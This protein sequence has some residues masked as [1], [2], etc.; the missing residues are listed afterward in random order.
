MFKW[1]NSSD[2][3]PS[4]HR[5]QNRT[6]KGSC[7]LG[8]L[9]SSDTSKQLIAS[10][11]ALVVKRNAFWGCLLNKYA[12]LPFKLLALHWTGKRWSFKSPPIGTEP[13]YV[14]SRRCRC[15][16]P[17]WRTFVL[18]D[19]S[20]RSNV[21]ASRTA[22]EVQ[23]PSSKAKILPRRSVA[24]MDALPWFFKFLP[25]PIYSKT[26]EQRLIIRD[27]VLG[28]QITLQYPEIIG[29]VFINPRWRL[30]DGTT[31][32][33]PFGLASIFILFGF[34]RQKV[35]TAFRF[36]NANPELEREACWSGYSYSFLFD[37]SCQKTP[38]FY[39]Q[40][41][42]Q[43]VQ[44]PF[45]SSSF[46]TDAGVDNYLYGNRLVSNS[47]TFPRQHIQSNLQSMQCSLSR[48]GNFHDIQ[49]NMVLEVV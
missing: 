23:T 27:R 13:S 34:S 20:H 21:C 6:V 2:V 25:S 41:H 47:T 17:P 36:Q 24:T 1:L 26:Q 4:W 29:N 45:H 9:M 42:C 8:R 43:Q 16:S 28:A 3:E 33:K 18:K 31:T 14:T 37:T 30:I 44:S 22:Q 15:W 12:F 48:D 40:K 35:P 5:D 39:L 7:T 38:N 10:I 46:R 11:L 32:P 19:P 49:L